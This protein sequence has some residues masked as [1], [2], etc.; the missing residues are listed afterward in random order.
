MKLELGDWLRLPSFLPKEAIPKEVVH[1]IDSSEKP[2]CIACSGGPDSLT[3]LLLLRLYWPQKKC[4]VLHYNHR[5]REASS[6]EEEQIRLL[7]K[8]LNLSLE[9]G[10]RKDA[11]GKS[12]SKL[13]CSRYNFFE[14]VLR[15]YNA[16]VLL[17]GHHQDDLF[18]TILMRLIRGVSLDG[19][20]APKAIQLMDGYCKLRPLL[21]FSKQ[22]IVHACQV[23]GIKFFEDSTNKID[24]CV[25]NRVR[26]HLIGQFD[27]VFTKTRW[28]YGF[29]RTCQILS[30]QRDFLNEVLSQKFSN[31]DFSSCEIERTKLDKLS[32]TEV[33][34]FFTRWLE[35][36]AV[37]E[38]HFNELDLLLETLKNRKEAVVTLNKI[39][40]I[41]FT[42]EKLF[43]TKNLENEKIFFQYWKQGILFFPHSYCLSKNFVPWSEILYKK[44]LRG[45]FSHEQCIFLD[46]DLFHG[47]YQVRLRYPGD[48]YCLLGR[49]HEKKVKDLLSSEQKMQSLP[50]I[51]DNKGAIAWIPGLPPS[52][53]FKVTERTKLC[54]FLVY[55]NE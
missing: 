50:V 52:D 25:R 45:E 22:Q 55:K 7:A 40:R 54:V 18:E 21:N 34:Y 43:L 38:I 29:S 3:L 11:E 5:I 15:F 13:R 36:H 16:S 2:L 17:L 19:L 49:K 42:P 1:S 33:R 48:R 27:V 14:K 23:C 8:Q 35:A 26:H 28:R 39:Q 37:R 10:Y 46:A 24:F 4:I 41:I 51:C 6:Y 47:P 20:I 31:Y 30:D 32:V 44:I 53:Q 9:V 12:E